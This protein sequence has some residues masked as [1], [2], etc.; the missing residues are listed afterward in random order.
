M[1]RTL[2]E[3]K[4]FIENLFNICYMYQEFHEKFKIQTKWALHLR[5]FQDKS[6]ENNCEK[7][8]DN[9]QNV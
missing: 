6:R 7:S 3:I 4:I 9:R 8:S 5:N 2:V 1:A